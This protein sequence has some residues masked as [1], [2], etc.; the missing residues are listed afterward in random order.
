[1]H[2]AQIMAYSRQII[3]ICLI[4]ECIDKYGCLNISLLNC[5]VNS[6]QHFFLSLNEDFMKDTVRFFY[7][8]KV[9]MI[10]VVFWHV[11]SG[12]SM[13]RPFPCSLLNGTRVFRGMGSSFPG[14]DWSLHPLYG[15]YLDDSPSDLAPLS[16]PLSLQHLCC[17]LWELNQGGELL[18][19]H[20]H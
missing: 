16:F 13:L 10:F 6:V 20:H 2:L 3:T 18:L 19:S 14:L 17:S 9:L 15:S 11:N 1:M 5:P 4:N 8:A 12:P 7:E